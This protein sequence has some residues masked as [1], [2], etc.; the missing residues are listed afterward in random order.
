MNGIK[1]RSIPNYT[2]H[3]PNYPRYIQKV[4]EA[5]DKAGTQIVSHY[6]E[7]NGKREHYA[8]QLYMDHLTLLL[9]CF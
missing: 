7:S 8:F 1:T 6:T 4:S 5:L 3:I 2:K 9:E